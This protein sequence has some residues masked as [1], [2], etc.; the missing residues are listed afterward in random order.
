MTLWSNKTQLWRRLGEGG[1]DVANE[2]DLGS[3]LLRVVGA[4]ITPPNHINYKLLTN[5]RIKNGK[6]EGTSPNW[7]RG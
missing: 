3:G 4:V 6:D 5:Q 2:L 7:R 1:D